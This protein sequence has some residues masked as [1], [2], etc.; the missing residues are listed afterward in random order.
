MKVGEK[1]R[2]TRKISG[3]TAYPD[4]SRA[5]VPE[6]VD[7]KQA[8]H[9]SGRRAVPGR[10]E[11]TGGEAA[12]FGIAA[13]HRQTIAG[14]LP[15]PLHRGRRS[16]PAVSADFA[17]GAKKRGAKPRV[18]AALSSAD[19]SPGAGMNSPS[20]LTI[21]DHLNALHLSGPTQRGELQCSILLR[22]SSVNTEFHPAEVVLTYGAAQRVSRR[23][24]PTNLL[25]GPAQGPAC[26]PH[27]RNDAGLTLDPEV[28]EAE[29]E[30]KGVKDRAVIVKCGATARICYRSRW[31]LRLRLR[32]PATGARSARGVSKLPRQG[33]KTVEG[34]EIG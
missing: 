6:R 14:A 18:K 32:L 30:I 25:R 28:I 8:P 27:S 15:R 29:S 5:I 9:R 4:G 11:V 7:G 3:G 26:P 13:R 21:A 17:R 12:K 16:E 22:D 33:V 23:S 1:R 2:S 19:A 10:K 20:S 24:P 31:S 34:K